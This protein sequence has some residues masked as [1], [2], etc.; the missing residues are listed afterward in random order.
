VSDF[1]RG[2]TGNSL[3]GSTGV[4]ASVTIPALPSVVHVL[5]SLWF[6]LTVYQWT[7]ATLVEWE[8]L[9][10]G[11]LRVAG[12]LSTPE[13]GAGT[14]AG[15]DSVSLSGLDLATLAG[16]TIVAQFA[17]AV[18]GAGVYEEITIQGHDI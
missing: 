18:P 9:V 3:V 12:M 16:Q 6:K 7:G 13:T 14:G 11:V 5:D 4:A 1:P 10:G 15:V 17:G 8:V 2:W